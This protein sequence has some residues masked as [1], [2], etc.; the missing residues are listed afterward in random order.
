MPSSH[1]CLHSAVQFAHVPLLLT[2]PDEIALTYILSAI[3][4]RKIEAC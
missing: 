4:G 2:T 3:H 1:L